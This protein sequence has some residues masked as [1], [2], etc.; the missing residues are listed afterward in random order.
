MDEE[1]VTLNGIEAIAYIH[2]DGKIQLVPPSLAYFFASELNFLL[3]ETWEGGEE[4]D[5]YSP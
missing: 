4:E 3:A 2:Q 5:D 1:K